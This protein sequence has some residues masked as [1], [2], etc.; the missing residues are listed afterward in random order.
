MSNADMHQIEVIFEWDNPLSKSNLV[1]KGWFLLRSELHKAQKLDAFKRLETAWERSWAYVELNLPWVH[2]KVH[3]WKVSFLLASSEGN[4]SLE[5]LGEE[6]TRPPLSS[7]PGYATGKWR[8]FKAS[9]GSSPF[10]MCKAISTELMIN[11][12]LKAKI[13]N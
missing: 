2:F 10:R 11:N 1:G 3:L 5:C 13:Q 8:D 6:G 7:Q 9:K 12:L 4:K